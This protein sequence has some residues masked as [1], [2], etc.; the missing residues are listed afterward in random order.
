MTLV[1]EIFHPQPGEGSERLTTFQVGRGQSWDQGV[2]VTRP[3]IRTIQ[4]VKVLLWEVM[5]SPLCKM[6]KQTGWTL[7]GMS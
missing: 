1:S 4:K 6:C 2:E 3:S 5:T 7:V